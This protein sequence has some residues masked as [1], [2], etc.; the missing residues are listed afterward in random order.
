MRMLGVV[1]VL[2][3]EYSGYEVEGSAHGFAAVTRVAKRK[4]KMRAV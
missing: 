1:G 4:K 2:G 3:G